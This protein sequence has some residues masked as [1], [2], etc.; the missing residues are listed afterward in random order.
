[1]EMDSPYGEVQSPQAN[2][3]TNPEGLQL[4]KMNHVCEGVVG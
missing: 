3:I 1:M 2:S 4:V